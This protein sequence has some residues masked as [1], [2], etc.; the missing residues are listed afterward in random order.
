M[1]KA[2]SSHVTSSPVTSSAANSMWGG[3][4]AQ[5][6]ADQMLKINASIDVDKRM[7][8]ED[9]TAS[10]AH[11][12]M[13]AKVGILTAEE[14]AQIIAG[15][16]Q[17][18]DEIEAGQF[19]FKIELEDIH[20]N[21]ES[22]LKAII[23]DVAGKLHTAR[24]RNDQ[25]VTDFRLWLRGALGSLDAALESFIAV[26]D[27]RV[28]EHRATAM[29]GFTHLQV[30]QPVTFGLH[31]D[32]YKQMMLRDRA[33]LADC[34]KR[35]NEN[36]LG[37]CALAG[38]SF[39][40]DRAMTAAELGFVR[41]MPN[42]MDA[43]SARD[44]VLEFLAAGSIL[45]VHL[46]RLAEEII[47][48]MSQP[49]AFIKLPDAYTTGSSIMPQKKNA[50]AA[51]L[52]R[53]KSGGVTGRLMQMLMTIKGLPLTYNKDMQDDKAATF[54]VYDTLA[55]CLA[56]MEG[57]IAGLTVNTARMAEVAEDGYATATELADWLVVQLGL[58]FREAHHVTGRIVKMAEAKGCRL[59]QLALAD[60][61]AVEPRINQG[62]FEVLSVEAALRRRG[63]TG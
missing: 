25:V 40:I 49:F 11:A 28:A 4:F 35:V 51:E 46:S 57:M 6:P 48:W 61:Q 62:I 30:A 26:L 20:M 22:R 17:V 14:S 59:S 43:V 63:L 1:S 44:F 9:I 3:R 53:G 13:L 39:P 21:V 27:Q 45:S 10:Q 19:E 58:P 31:L 36:P 54:E 41:P 47:L 8:R 7:Y 52:V 5:A 18:L 55:L 12:R 29:P 23:G 42:T 60:M 16:S 2:P 33:R 50:D 56:A 37:A 34:A 15:L 32:A 24:S 38:T